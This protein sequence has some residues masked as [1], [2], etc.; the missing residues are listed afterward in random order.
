M[1]SIHAFPFQHL[2]LPGET[3][4]WSDPKHQESPYSVQF[5]TMAIGGV[6]P[7]DLRYGW[8]AES[9]VPVGTALAGRI[10]PALEGEL[11]L[12]LERQ[13]RQLQS[14]DFAQLT[15]TGTPR[16]SSIDR[17][18]D[19]LLVVQ[20]DYTSILWLGWDNRQVILC[21]KFRFFVQSHSSAAPEREQSMRKLRYASAPVSGDPPFETWSANGASRFLDETVKG[22]GL[23]I[24]AAVDPGEFPKKASKHDTTQLQVAGKAM[25]FP[26]TLWKTV[27]GIAY[28]ANND[29]GV[30][31][32]ELEGA[33]T[34]P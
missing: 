30:T 15:G 5:S 16:A 19:R 32:V 10:Q 24:A 4:T 7:V 18:G 22:W 6:V 31:L 3:R 29:G 14:V 11:R 21:G 13:G 20:K 17:G 23:L 1:G 25:T 12:S 28:V 8:R 2:G 26:G 9:M 27:D 34:T 33:P